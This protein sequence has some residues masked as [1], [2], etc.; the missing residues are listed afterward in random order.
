MSRPKKLVEGETETMVDEYLP[1]VK[2]VIVPI[3][4]G[5]T[6][7]GAVGVREADRVVSEWVDKGYKLFASFR[8]EFIPG[9]RAQIVCV[10]V[11]E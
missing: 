9:D 8:G 6:G 10:L 11:R 5:N 2:F 1:P 7:S 3:A 4:L